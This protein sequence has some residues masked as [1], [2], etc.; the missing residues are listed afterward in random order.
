MVVLVDRQKRTRAD[1]DS[2]RVAHRYLIFITLTLFRLRIELETILPWIP[3]T[4]PD[5]LGPRVRSMVT[6]QPS[7]RSSLITRG[8][9]VCSLPSV[10]HRLSPACTTRTVDSAERWKH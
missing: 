6:V 8:R 9:C 7:P 10:L 1:T 5:I 3:P 4:P 2:R